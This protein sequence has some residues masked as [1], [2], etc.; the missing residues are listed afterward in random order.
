MQYVALT[1]NLSQRL[2]RFRKGT[3]WSALEPGS[4]TSYAPTNY[5]IR[6]LSNPSTVSLISFDPTL[7]ETMSAEAVSLDQTAIDVSLQA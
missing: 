3:K 5:R 2:D 6:L 1:T 4:R 7:M